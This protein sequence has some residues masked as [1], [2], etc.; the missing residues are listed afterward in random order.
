MD[1]TDRIENDLLAR[2]LSRMRGM[3]HAYNRKFFALLLPSVVA[4][5]LAS[6]IEADHFYPHES[7][8]V[9]GFVPDRPDT[10]FSMFTPHFTTVWAATIA[11]TLRISYDIEGGL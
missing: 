7:S 6:E 1:E 3:Q 5:A 4:I 8:K 11:A 10:F 9:G 2:R